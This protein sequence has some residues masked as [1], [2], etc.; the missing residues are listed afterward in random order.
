MLPDN[1]LLTY[2]SKSLSYGEEVR[3]KKVYPSLIIPSTSAQVQ[4][5]HLTPSYNNT[6]VS[7]T[8]YLHI[9]VHR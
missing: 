6:Q 2:L 1:L 7:Y 3:D 9:T 4:V 8:L 5:S